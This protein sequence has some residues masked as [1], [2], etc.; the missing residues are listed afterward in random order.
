MIEPTP[1]P[2]YEVLH[3]RLNYDAKTGV[4]TWKDRATSTC[5]REQDARCWNKKYSGS[6]AGVDN[7]GHL[8]LQ[9]DGIKYFNHRIVWKMVTGNEPEGEIDHH[10]LDRKDNRFENLRDVT[11]GQNARNKQLSCRNKS[12]FKGVDFKKDGGKWRARI[13][14]NGIQSCLGYFDTPEEAAQAY[15][16]AVEPYHG[17][18]GRIK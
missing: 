6:V 15:I 12:G 11:S 2:S 3:S 18:F 17:E 4:L 1:L 16:D 7:H 8:R 5:K 14:V 10:N 9:I 13:R